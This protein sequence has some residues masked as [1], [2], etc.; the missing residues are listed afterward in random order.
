[1]TEQTAMSS[2]DAEQPAKAEAAGHKVRIGDRDMTLSE[3]R[4]AMNP[5]LAH[6]VEQQFPR[7]NDSPE[8]AQQMVEAY[9][10]EHERQHG[11]SWAGQQHEARQPAVHESAKSK[12][13]HA[14]RSHQR[15]AHERK[16]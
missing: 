12:A 13:A 8:L 11:Q 6:Q 10:A 4:A 16:G 15:E 5:A 14:E 1:M 3:A 9:A 7:A 2:T